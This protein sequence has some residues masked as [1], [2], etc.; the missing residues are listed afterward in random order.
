MSNVDLCVGRFKI[1]STSSNVN[2]L[3]AEEVEEAEETEEVEKEAEEVEKEAEVEKEKA[4]WDEWVTES[5]QSF[6]MVSRTLR[7]FLLLRHRVKNLRQVQ[8]DAIV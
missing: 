5:G 7:A 2:N 3:E 1:V 6:S 4:H 8:F